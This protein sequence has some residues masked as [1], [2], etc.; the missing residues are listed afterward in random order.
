MYLLKKYTNYSYAH[1]GCMVG[2]RDHATVI[3][4]DKMVRNLREVDKKFDST[5]DNLENILKN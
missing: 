1:I 3:H 4:S 5:M 2:N